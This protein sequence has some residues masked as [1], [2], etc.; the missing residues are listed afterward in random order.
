MKRLIQL[1]ILCI[2]AAFGALLVAPAGMASQQATNGQSTLTLKQVKQRLKQNKQYL[3]EAEKRGKA[4]DTTGME[5][6]L[7]NYDRGMEGLNTA[8]SKGQFQ[9]RPSQ[10]EDAYHH[11]QTATSKHTKVLEKLL[12]SGKIPA[13]AVPHIRHAI[14][15]SRMGQKTALSHLSQLQA[16]RGMGQAN[17][18]GFGQSHGMGR[19]QGAGSPGG[20]GGFGPANAPMGGAMGH[21]GGGPGMGGG[22]HGR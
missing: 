6:A 14:D 18:P 1:G 13:Q 10:M 19:P 15:V 22:H 7:N 11:V 9:G 21:P 20:M 3:K 17:R 4:G 12:K 8:L 2:I 5:T 16:Q